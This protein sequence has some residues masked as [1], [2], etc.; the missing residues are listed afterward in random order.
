MVALYKDKI[1]PRPSVEMIHVSL[2]FNQKAALSWAKEGKFPWPA[3]PMDK[4][5]A[6]G[7]SGLTP[8]QAP[9]YLLINRKGDVLAKGKDAALEKALSLTDGK[10]G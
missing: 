1:A 2:D 5:E 7:L 8:R 6:A 4:I 3:V 9:A 10:K